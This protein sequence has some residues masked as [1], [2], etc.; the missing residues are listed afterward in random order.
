MARHLIECDNDINCDVY[1]RLS[2]E[3][4]HAHFVEFEDQNN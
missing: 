3:T 2:S 4:K 1:P